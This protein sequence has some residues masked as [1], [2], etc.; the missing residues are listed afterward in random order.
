MGARSALV[1]DAGRSFT[2]SVRDV[3]HSCLRIVGDPR[4]SRKAGQAVHRATSAAAARQERLAMRAVEVA[5]C[6][7]CDEKS[8]QRASLPRPPEDVTSPLAGR[9][10]LRSAGQCARSSVTRAE[11]HAV[12]GGCHDLAGISPFFR[13]APCRQARISTRVPYPAR[14]RARSAERDAAGIRRGGAPPRHRG[15][16]AVDAR[17]PSLWRHGSRIRDRNRRH[18]TVAASGNGHQISAAT[19]VSQC[20]A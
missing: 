12:L 17:G 1:A 19:A 3:A 7:P 9:S 8:L 6:P 2:R 10:F 18:E 4:R 16:Q 11:H 15:R 13:S 14:V 20:P 5:C